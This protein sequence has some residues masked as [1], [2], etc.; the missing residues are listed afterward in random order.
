VKL[1]LR[2]AMLAAV[3]SNVAC[4]SGSPGGRTASD[5]FEPFNRAMFS[6]NET[7][8]DVV[9]EPAARAYVN[10]VPEAFRVTAGNVFANI[11]DLWT[12]AN[13]LLQGKPREAIADFSRVFINT[14]VGFA[15]FADVA[16]PLGFERHREDFGQTLG[17]WG[18]ESGP[19][20]VLPVFGPSTVRDGVGLVGDLMA[21]P[22]TRTADRVDVR[23]SV[24]ALRIVD[25]RAA[26][27]SAGRVL[28]GAALDKY[29]FVRDGYLQ[30]RYNLVWDGDPPSDRDPADEPAGSR[31]R[32]P[33]AAGNTGKEIR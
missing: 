26:L 25:D 5:P 1:V 8:D 15:G 7:L 9:A 4:A 33:G 30:R 19:Y 24:R 31:A 20:L 6:F 27:L 17:R 12:A 32:P 23:N 2:A 11:R 18:I 10:V 28:D 21:D 14:T 29:T 3:L 16:A 13:Q 22:V